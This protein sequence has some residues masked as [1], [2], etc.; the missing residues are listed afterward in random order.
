MTIK[1]V[2]PIH[3]PSANAFSGLRGA[4]RL[5]IDA[6]AGVT[7]IVEDL[8]H[9]IAGAAPIAGKAPAGRT[10]GITG[11]VYRSVRGVTRESQYPVCCRS[12]SPTGGCHDA[13]PDRDCCRLQE[14]P[15]VC[16]LPFKERDW[17]CAEG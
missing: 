15:G 12:S 6:A 10:T 16:R 2:A 17:R 4:S 3:P 7:D 1:P 14:M 11:L 5:A 13:L 9:S 8:H